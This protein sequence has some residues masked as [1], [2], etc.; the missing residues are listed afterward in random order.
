MKK[1]SKPITF[2]GEQ[3]PRYNHAVIIVGGIGSD[4]K[5]VIND[6]MSIEGEV[7]SL[8]KKVEYVL[9]NDSIKKRILKN[10]GV[11][12]DKFDQSNPIEKAELYYYV[13]RF[14]Y[15]SNSMSPVESVSPPK[16]D[17]ERIPNCIIQDSVEDT[18]DFYNE[19]RGLNRWSDYD[20]KD[21]HLVWVINDLEE[22]VKQYLA[23]ANKNI[24]DALIRSSFHSITRLMKQILNGSM[25]LSDYMDG[26]IW[27]VF[28]K[29]TIVHFKKSG[30][31][32]DKS[33]LTD[34]V[35]DAIKERIPERPRLTFRPQSSKQSKRKTKK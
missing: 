19:T 9:R 14:G 24:S 35:I 32:I 34:E 15:E 23:N 31:P 29:D 2:A 10:K 4:K 26:D 16:I 28:D 11:D 27:L 22:V 6:L 18:I 20:K 33:K 30:S 13:E 8:E 5:S 25:A 12:L 21:I 17:P 1:E 3:Y 7:Y